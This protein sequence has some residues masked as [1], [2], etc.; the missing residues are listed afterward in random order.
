VQA[1]GQ[2]SRRR[3]IRRKSEAQRRKRAPC[4]PALEVPRSRAKCRPARERGFVLRLWAA[5]TK[6]GNARRGLWMLVPCPTTLHSTQHLWYVR[7]EF[8]F[9]KLKRLLAYRL[10]PYHVIPINTHIYTHP[11]TAYHSCY[12]LHTRLANH[13]LSVVFVDPMRHIY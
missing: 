5:A 1:A 9:D 4:L 13:L 3:R 2:R 8:S 6:R 10:T 7:E 12:T 11:P